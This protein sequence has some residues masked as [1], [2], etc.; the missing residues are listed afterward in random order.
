MLLLDHIGIAATAIGRDLDFRTVFVGHALLDRTGF[1]GGG[2]QLYQRRSEGFHAQ[3][4]N[5]GH[6][7]VEPQM[8]AAELIPVIDFFLV[9]KTV[10]VGIRHILVGADGDFIG[11][12]QAIAIGIGRSIATA[13]T[14]AVVVAWVGVR[15]AAATGSE[16]HR[17]NDCE[18]DSAR[19]LECFHAG[20]LALRHKKRA[21]VYKRR[22]PGK[23]LKLVYSTAFHPLR[24][25]RNKERKSLEGLG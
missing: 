17:K 11:I 9:R 18:Q 14:A 12:A 8:R 21:Y 22:K 3:P 1:L 10:S 4:G 5:I 7:W 2:I 19:G 13:I 23:P 6:Q 25:H 20:L 15:T 16:S 24:E